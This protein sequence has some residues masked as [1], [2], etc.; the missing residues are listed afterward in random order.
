MCVVYLG[1][2]TERKRSKMGS[3]HLDCKKNHLRVNIYWQ[4]LPKLTEKGL[5]G[6]TFHAR[7]S[8]VDREAIVGRAVIILPSSIFTSSAER[9]PISE[10]HLSSRISIP[11]FAADDKLGIKIMEWNGTRVL[12]VYVYSLS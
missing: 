3:D 10:A 5:L 11:V 1:K 8:V 12:R 9:V 6:I 4:V 7:A 2:G